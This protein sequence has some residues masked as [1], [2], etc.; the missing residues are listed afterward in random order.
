VTGATPPI[1]L[2]T[3]TSGNVPVP[4]AEP[5]PTPLLVPLRVSRAKLKAE[6]DNWAAN[7]QAYRRRGWILLDGNLDDLRV[8]VGFVSLVALGEQQIPFLSAAVRLT[9][10]NYDLWPPSLTFIEPRSGNPAP[11]PVQA[12][13]RVDGGEPRNALLLHPV[14]RR[15]FLCLP[16]LREYHS[17]PQHSGDDWLLHRAEGAGRVAVICDRIWRRMVLNVVGVQMNLLSVPGM[18]VQLNIGIAQGDLNAQVQQ[19]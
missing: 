16:G 7:A 12:I 6:L 1:A 5:A 8:E 13:E 15:P 2:A 4:L 9:Y 18:G 11:P 14:T 19:A 17:H 10:E 3:G